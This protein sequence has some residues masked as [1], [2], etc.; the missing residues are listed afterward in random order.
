[1]SNYL[2]IPQDQINGQEYSIPVDN[3]VCVVL[4]EG[5]QQRYP[6]VDI[7][8]KQMSVQYLPGNDSPPVRDL[9]TTRLEALKY[10]GTDEQ[11]RGEICEAI[12]KSMAEPNSLN[13]LKIKRASQNRQLIRVKQ[14]YD[15]YS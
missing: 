10:V 3:I 11:F 15:F 7:I 12:I 4:V 9:T 8:Y 1:M 14:P 6:K 13:E 5:T 2:I